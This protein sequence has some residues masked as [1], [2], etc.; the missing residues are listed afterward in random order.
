MLQDFLLID[1]TQSHAIICPTPS[2]VDG[3]LLTMAQDSHSVNIS[4]Q[5]QNCMKYGINCLKSHLLLTCIGSKV[6]EVKDELLLSF[7]TLRSTQLISY[8]MTCGSYCVD[9]TLLI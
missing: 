7:I 9:P 3:P 5:K 1:C 4:E 2:Q 8:F 6:N